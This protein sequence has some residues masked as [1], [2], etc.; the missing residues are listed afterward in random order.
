MVKKKSDDA[1]RISSSKPS[2]NALTAKIN[3]QEKAFRLINLPFYLVNQ[4]E[5]I[6]SEQ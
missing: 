5:R 2:V 6:V 4:I 1:I 3:K